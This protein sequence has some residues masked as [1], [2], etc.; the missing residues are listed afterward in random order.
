VLTGPSGSYTYQWSTGSSANS[1]NVNQSGIYWLQ[2]ENNTICQFRDSIKVTFVPIPNPNLGAD[3]TLCFGSSM[4]LTDGL[5]SG[6][7]IWSTCVTGHS[8]TINTSGSY[9]VTSSSTS[10]CTNS[11]TINISLV[12]PSPIYLGIDTML[13]DNQLLELNA[14]SG[15]S[16]YLWST[17]STDYHI[18]VSHPGTYWVQASDGPCT[19]SDA[20][21]ILP[22]PCNV[23]IPNTFTPND[24]YINEYFRIVANN[25][26]YLNMMIFNRWGELLYEESDLNAKWDGKYKGQI[27]PEGVY[28]CVIKYKCEFTQDKLYQASTSVTLVK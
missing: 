25:L 23:W 1:I 4:V 19:T 20:I 21:N 12:Q 2:I 3:T 11:D 17:G 18:Y 9:W 15:F 16:G 10:N 8:I 26:S 6:Y 28:F 7:S 27:C 22:C 14:G 5:N 24:D 13:C